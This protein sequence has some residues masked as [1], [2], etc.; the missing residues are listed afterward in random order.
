MKLNHYDYFLRG[1]LTDAG[2][3]KV[4]MIL[5]ENGVTADKMPSLEE[6]RKCHAIVFYSVLFRGQKVYC[7][8]GKGNPFQLVN[9]VEL[10]RTDEPSQPAEVIVDQS[11]ANALIKIRVIADEALA[12]LK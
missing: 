7:N 5:F 4:R 3:E 8:D 2:I 6:M 11:L 12:A 10:P 1:K 9:E